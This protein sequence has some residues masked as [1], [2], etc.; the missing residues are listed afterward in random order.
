MS[1][2]LTSKALETAHRRMLGVRYLDPQMDFGNGLSVSSFT[3]QVE[4]MKAKLDAYNEMV[5]TLKQ[6]REAIEAMEKSLRGTSERMLGAVASLY[7]KESD[8]YEVAGGVKRGKR[9]RR[10]AGEPADADTGVTKTV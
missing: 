1:R 3:D 5:N 2:V 4:T 8:E 9:S 10:K 7:G 6:E